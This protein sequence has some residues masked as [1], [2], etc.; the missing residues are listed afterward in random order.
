ME[1]KKEGC[2]KQIEEGKDFCE[3]HGK[4]VVAEE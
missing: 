1:C 2:D 4:P 3:E